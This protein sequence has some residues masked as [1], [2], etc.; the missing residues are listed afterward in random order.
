MINYITTDVFEFLSYIDFLSNVVVKSKFRATAKP[1][2]P[3]KKVLA[4]IDTSLEGN[5]GSNLEKAMLKIESVIMDTS[6]TSATKPE[7]REVTLVTKQSASDQ[8][9]L[10]SS[11]AGLDEGNNSS[12]ATD[13]LQNSET[14]TEKQ[15][16][17]NLLVSKSAALAKTSNK[18]KKPP[19][20]IVILSRGMG[21]SPTAK[22][23]N[24]TP[25]IIKNKNIGN[26]IKRTTPTAGRVRAISDSKI[27][28]KENI[29][30]D[31]VVTEEVFSLHI[32]SLKKRRQC[33]FFL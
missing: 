21:A 33:R 2:E 25:T 30:E 32:N 14:V 7:M 16:N 31:C 4:A 27:S 24:D 18:P 20:G 1:F 3:S 17:S 10:T 5:K 19:V 28:R 9:S 23:T 26:S 15:K 13:H 8:S 29:E 12:K 11:V 22:L 6:P